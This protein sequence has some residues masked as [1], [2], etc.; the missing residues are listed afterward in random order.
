M[1]SASQMKFQGIQP[2]Y[3]TVHDR[4]M[5]LLRRCKGCHAGEH[6]AV[7]RALEQV[8]QV[9]QPRAMQQRLV[10][11]R[12]HL[13]CTRNICTIRGM[14]GLQRS[15]IGSRGHG[16]TEVQQ[17]KAPKVSLWVSTCQLHDL[18]QEGVTE[19]SG[20]ARR[21]LAATCA[22]KCTYPHLTGVQGG[23]PQCG[24]W[25]SRLRNSNPKRSAEP[26]RY[27]PTRLGPICLRGALQTGKNIKDVTSSTH[28]P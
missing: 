24:C 12:I 17:K 18:C 6:R 9:A 16:M 21:R 8:L 15:H 13:Q 5:F 14:K 2:V 22:C 25:T 19:W 3:S 26:N 20:S 4:H 7:R 23:A 28:P 11:A 10:V 1:C 27:Q